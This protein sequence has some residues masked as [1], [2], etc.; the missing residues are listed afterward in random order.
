MQRFQ[1]H[2]GKRAVPGRNRG[3]A[4]HVESILGGGRFRGGGVVFLGSHT[5]KTWSS[6]QSVIAL[7]S[8]EAEY[9]GMVKTAAVAMG[10]RTI[11]QDMNIRL[12]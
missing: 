1:V 4:S 3:I 2:P 10:I 9:Y 6:T 11:L 7:S 8:G 5:V 12:K